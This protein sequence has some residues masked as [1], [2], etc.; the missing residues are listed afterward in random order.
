M[1]SNDIEEPGNTNYRT[2]DADAG[3]S[4]GP[5]GLMIHD[6][7]TNDM[8]W[9]SSSSSSPE[10]S[11]TRS[12]LKGVT[13]RFVASMTTVAIAWL[14]IGEPGIAFQIGFLEAIIKILVYYLHERIWAKIP[15]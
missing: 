1:G 14:V 9:S 5:D 7:T 4:T 13:W 10:E 11:H 15:V 2:M 6:T 3:A 12:I 8:P